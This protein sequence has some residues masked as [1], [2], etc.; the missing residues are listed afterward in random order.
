MAEKY[1]VSMA[2]VAI[3]WA[4]SKPFISA[5]ILGLSEKER[6]DEAIQAIDFKLSNEEIKSIDEMYQP[7]AVI[8]HK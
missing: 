2:I 1:G 4:L 3:A 8:S 7:K 6:V 5:P